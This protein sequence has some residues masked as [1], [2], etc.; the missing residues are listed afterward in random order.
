MDNPLILVTGATGYIGGRLVPRLL[1]SGYNVRAM[2]R[3]LNKL[4]GRPWIDMPNLELIQADL[5]D[6]RTLKSTVK[7]CDIAYYLV[8]SMSPEHKNFVDA[9][10]RAA[11]NFISIS[12]QINLKRIIYL[13]GL[14]GEEPNT[15]P[16]LKSRLEVEKI[17]HV[18]RLHVE[19]LKLQI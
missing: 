4:R 16:H 15:S 9:D 3:S 14:G 19:K 1:K 2:A 7:G 5:H 11:L 18:A 13:G 12:D 17:L 8:H 6:I 10:R